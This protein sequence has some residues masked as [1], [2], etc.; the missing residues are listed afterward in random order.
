MKKML[1][2]LALTCMI[3]VAKAQVN[4][5]DTTVRSVAAKNRSVELNANVLPDGIHLHWSKGPDDFIA[6]FELYRS[7][8]GASYNIIKQFR[9]DVFDANQNSYSFKDHEPLLG[10]NFYRLVGY[11]KYTHQKNVV[12]IVAEYYNMPK[13]IRPTLVV[14]G[15]HLNISHYDGRELELVVYNSGAT[16][17]FK[18]VISSAVIPLPGNLSKGLYVYQLADRKRSIVATGKFVLQ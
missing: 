2:L 3:T 12:N 5:F 17:M 14:N 8:D 11:D 13:T 1:C 15:D 10:K 4:E 18:R 16:P 7:S 9:P 6:Y